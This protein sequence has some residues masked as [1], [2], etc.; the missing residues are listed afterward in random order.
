MAPLTTAEIIAQ[1]DYLTDNFDPKSLTVA[2]LL[3]LF[4]HHGIRCPANAKKSALISL[5]EKEITGNIDELREQRMAI[6][7][8]QASDRGIMDGV[9]GK[10]IN[11]PD[12]SLS[13]IIP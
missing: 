7:G 3:G 2:Q 9:S 13:M 1:A 11:D 5:F 10:Q 8:S 12:V 6:D 4:S